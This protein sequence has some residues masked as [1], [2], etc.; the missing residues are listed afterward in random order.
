[1]RVADTIEGNMRNT[2]IIL[3]GKAEYKKSLGRPRR[4]W[5]YIKIDLIQIGKGRMWNGF[6]F[7]RTGTSGGLF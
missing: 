6:I 3:F 7:L 2:Y 5:K 4:Q 1:V